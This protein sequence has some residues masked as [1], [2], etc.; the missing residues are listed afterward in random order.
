MTERGGWALRMTQLAVIATYFLSSWAK[1]RFGGRRLADQRDAGA[2]DDPTRHAADRPLHVDP[3]GP[4][5]R[6]SSA[7]SRSSCRVRSCSLSG[8]RLRYWIMGYFY[9]STDG[10]G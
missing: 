8:A 1:L 6:L 2:G 4:C 10:D 3:V 5:C 7:S 9:L